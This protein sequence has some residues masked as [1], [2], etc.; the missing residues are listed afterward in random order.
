[1]NDQADHGH[2]SSAE[3]RDVIQTDTDGCMVHG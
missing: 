1:M 3:D 2:P